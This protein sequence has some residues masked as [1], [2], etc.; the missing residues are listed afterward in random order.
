M[1]RMRP[2]LVP[3]AVAALLAATL[4]VA[5][6]AVV[7]FLVGALYVAALDPLVTR[8]AP[9]TGRTLG[10]LLAIGLSLGVLGGVTTLLAAPL[11]EQA[12]RVA[13]DLPGL[14]NTLQGRIESLLAG[15]P[16]DLEPLARTQLAHLVDGVAA[17][18]AA[19]A[20]AGAALVG[21]L[22]GTLLAY[23]TIPFF[24][25]Y[26]LRDRPSLARGLAGALPAG[27]RPDVRAILAITGSV[28]GRWIRA[29]ILLSATIGVGVFVI[30]MLLGLFVDPVFA[31]YALVLALLAALL[32]SLPIIGPI[33]AAIPAVA[34]GAISGGPGP[35]LVV[36]AAYIAIQQI[37]GSILVPRIS[38]GAI[39]VHPAYVIVVIPVGAA[40]AGPLGAVLALPVAALIRDLALYAGARLSARPATPA[41]AARLAGIP[42]PESLE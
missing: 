7:P 20:P 13:G 36:L 26:V 17:A 31:R 4:L 41:A 8:F 35:A 27:Y 30:L 6:E 40:L 28:F 16:D 14:A 22:T 19:A 33:L 24:A 18:L 38:G 2:Y 29:Q 15:L 25:F 34:V 9:R 12:G 37:E 11:L 23:A 32:E 3:V 21:S 1:T 10:A 5:R 42:L 39:R